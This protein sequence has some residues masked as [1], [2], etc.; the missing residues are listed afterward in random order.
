MEKG[1]PTRHA[2]SLKKD[3][4]HANNKVMKLL[5][6]VEISPWLFRILVRYLLSYIKDTKH[7][8][9]IINNTH[10]QSS[11]KLIFT[12]DVKSLYTVIPYQDSL[13]ALKFFLDK[14]PTQERLTT[15]LFRS[16]ELVLTLNNFL[17]DDE[18]YQQITGV[19]M[20]TKMG[21]KYTNL[22]GFVEQHIYE[23]CNGPLHDYLGRFIDDCLGTALCSCVEL[24]RF[25]NSVDCKMFFN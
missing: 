3:K 1:F 11:H 8:L 14:R 20:G 22:L 9:Q 5:W 21:P 4:L 25:I 7:A 13:K 6:E 2:L 24:E 19:A 23:Q 16:A 12:V 10:F 17:F 15:V 18:H